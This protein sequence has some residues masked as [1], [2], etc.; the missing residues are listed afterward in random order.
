VELLY[1]VLLSVCLSNIFSHVYC[2]RQKFPFQKHTEQKT[3]ARKW[4][5][6]NFMVLVSETCVMDLKS[7]STSEESCFPGSQGGMDHF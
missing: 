7:T 6:F 1:A 3:D 4:S 2:R 5:Q